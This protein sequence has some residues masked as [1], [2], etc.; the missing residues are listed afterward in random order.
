MAPNGTLY[1][2]APTTTSNDNIYAVSP[3]GDVRVYYSG[4]GR[5]QGLAMGKNGD[6]LVAASLHGSRGMVC[7]TPRGRASLA[8]A[9]NGIVGLAGLPDGNFV[10]ATREALYHL[11]G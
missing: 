7:I 6:L 4:L 8:V 9:G 10:L 1:V 5:P 11:R 3:E 2:S